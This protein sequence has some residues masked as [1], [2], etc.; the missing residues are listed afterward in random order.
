MGAE[1]I[2]APLS[3][4]FVAPAHRSLTRAVRSYTQLPADTTRLKRILAPMKV[5]ATGVVAGDGRGQRALRSTAALGLHRRHPRVPVEMCLEGPDWCQTT[6]S[7]P[8]E[9]YHVHNNVTDAS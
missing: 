1:S 5:P 2:V 9:R 4:G 8:L 7:G 6:V 3:A